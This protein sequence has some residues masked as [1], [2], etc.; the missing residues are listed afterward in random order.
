MRKR[1]RVYVQR[2]GKMLIVIDKPTTLGITIFRRGHIALQ[3]RGHFFQAY[4]GD[5]MH[6]AGRRS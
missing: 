5:R 2:N 1:S 4:I 6:Y 3:W